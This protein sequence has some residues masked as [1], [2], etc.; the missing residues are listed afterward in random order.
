MYTHTSQWITNFWATHTETPPA[1]TKLVN[2]LISANRQPL[3]L[4]E[5]WKGSTSKNNQKLI[6]ER[7]VP[8]PLAIQPMCDN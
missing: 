7:F 4:I 8:K 3:Y 2:L 1:M 6:I 5:H